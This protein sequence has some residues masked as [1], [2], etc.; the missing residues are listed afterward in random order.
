MAEQI[1]VI[2][3]DGHILER[4]SDIRKYLDPRWNERK[5]DLWAR[6]QPWDVEL[7][8]KLTGYPGYPKR[9]SAA[10]QVE[11]WLKVMDQYGMEEA[12]LFPTGSGNITKLR[13]KE[14]VI[15]AVQACNDHFAREYN[16]LSG[17][18]HA[19][20]VLPLRWP[21]E[22]AKELRRAVTELGLVSFE[23]LTL[24]LETALGDPIYD[25]IYAEAARLDVPLSIHGNRN[26]SSEIGTSTLN[27]FNEMHT[28]AF[29][30][31]L[32]L[33]FTSI[34]F[35]GV[36]VKF[37]GLRLSFLEAGCTWL[38]YWL[39]RMDEHWEMR[40]EVEAPLLKKKPSDIVRESPI[41]F[42]VEASESFLPQV[43]DFIGDDHFVYASD[44]PHWDGE[45]P[46]NL[47]GIRN[48]PALSRETK[49]K[50]LYHNSRAFFGLGTPTAAATAR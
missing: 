36:P 13:E 14:F 46:G 49:E 45:F 47:D 2:D 25:P 12:V 16:A 24:G 5:T 19:V 43:I 1:P 38:P 18:I 10:E 33:Q 9:Q 26:N 37:P 20:G 30:V 35:Q 29:P 32:L 8:G 41:Y 48:H 15:D 31:G 39:D 17:R 28:Y 44:I 4:Q 21:E 3:A 27:T 7:S 40:G 22:A 50:V 34:M 11:F 42:S 6:D 23:L